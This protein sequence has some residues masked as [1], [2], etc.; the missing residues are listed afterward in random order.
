MKQGTDKEQTMEL[1]EKRAMSVLGLINIAEGEIGDYWDDLKLEI[2]ESFPEAS[3]KVLF[4]GYRNSHVEALS[5]AFQ[6]ALENREVDP[7]TGLIF[8][9][10]EA[11]SVLK[12]I[13]K[14]QGQLMTDAIAE[15]RSSIEEAREAQGEGYAEADRATVVGTP[16][17]P[18]S[19][20][21]LRQGGY[22]A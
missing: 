22:W 2:Y 19:T 1:N 3:S 13:S 6:D 12:E 18:Y 7:V 5:R 15:L 17:P 20:A 21:R 14:L 10:D 9:D 8:P 4:S 16:N 11:A